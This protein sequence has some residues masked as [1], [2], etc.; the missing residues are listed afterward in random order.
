MKGV[1]NMREIIIEENEAEQR[2]DRFL[3]K[4]LN[5]STRTNVYKILRKKLIKVNGKRE[6][7][8][9]F[10]KLNDRV[11]IFLSNE[12]VDK[13]IKREDKPTITQVNLDIVYE[14]DEI[15]VV[16]KPKGLLTHPDKKEYTKTLSTKVL[17]YLKDLTSRTFKPAS[18]N[19]LDHNTSGLVLFCKTYEALKKYNRLMRRR[20]IKKY[21]LCI[22]EGLVKNEG[23]I[24]GYLIKDSKK[25]TV[26]I[27]RENK[28]DRGKFV[29]TKYKPIKHVGNY[30]LLEVEILT[31][32][33]HQI[34]ASLSEINHPIVGD[35]KY[36]GKKIGD[37]TT[38]VLHAYKMVIE[39]KVFIKESEEINKIL[40]MID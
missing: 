21:Y 1:N 2:L 24:K 18:V 29:H 32:R 39:D 20:E 40:D 3:L 13:L 23:E 5:N 17:V 36:G 25:N 8:N 9:Y 7:E 30:T 19:R 35:A 33:T 11:Q 31:G 14:D 15:L 37:I 34:R 10:L 6:K 26:N 27:L 38:Q 4:Y 28:G 12:A 22:V 16:N